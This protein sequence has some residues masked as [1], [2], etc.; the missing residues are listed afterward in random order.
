M[1]T[2]LPPLPKAWVVLAKPPAA[3]STAWVYG[4]FRPEKVM[5][6]PDIAGMEACLAAGEVAGVASRLCN[7][8]E[9]VT[10]EAHPVIARLKAAMLAAGAMASLMSGSGPTVFGLAA[11]KEKAEKIAAAVREYGAWVTVTE[12]VSDA[13]G[14]NGTKVA[15]D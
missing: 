12:T 5:G 15:A 1:L 6:R 13:G 7:V 11:S 10:I 8:L 14:E 9:T 2:P 4:N 3:V